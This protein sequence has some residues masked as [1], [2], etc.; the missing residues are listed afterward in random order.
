M[1]DV[2]VIHALPDMRQCAGGIAAMLPALAT[3][4]VGEGVESRMTGHFSDPGSTW[5]P[6][7]TLLSRGSLFLGQEM[8][9][10]VAAIRNAA[11]SH[12]RVICHSHGLWSPLNH[13][14]AQAARREGLP[15]VVS[16]HGM[17]LPWARQNRKWRKDIA[18]ALYQRRDLARADAIHVTSREE[19]LATRAEIA[20]DRILEIPFGVALPGL[21]QAALAPEGSRSRRLLFLGRVHPIKN[22][23]GLIEAFALADVPGWTLLIVGPDEVGHRAG[24]VRRAAELGVQDRVSFGEAVYGQDKDA[25]LAAVD[26]LILPSFSENYGAVVAEALAAGRP[27][28]ASTG[29]PWCEVSTERCGWWVDPAAES[30]S[31]A[32]R[33]LAATSPQELGMMGMRGREY[34]SRRLAWSFCAGRMAALYRSL[35]DA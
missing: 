33:A 24:L 5:A 10:A 14:L 11:G 30:L 19:C 25:L 6:G 16:V 29:T 20:S 32:M 9:G 2:T 27:V 4:L 21:A 7:T 31:G 23:T 18:W 3:A 28:I 22:L 1:S 17:L 13:A 26:A 12:G 8:R 35:L 15:L 34:A